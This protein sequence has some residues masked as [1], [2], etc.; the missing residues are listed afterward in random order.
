MKHWLF[1]VVLIILG[2]IGWILQGHARETTIYSICDPL[3]KIEQ[4]LMARHGET[5]TMEGGTETGR[6]STRIY[7]NAETGSFTILV[8]DAKTKDACVVAVG[9]GLEPALA[10]EP[11]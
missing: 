8:V 1:Y 4:S 7:Q 3:E 5:V 6:A 11:A 9:H 10:G 2:L